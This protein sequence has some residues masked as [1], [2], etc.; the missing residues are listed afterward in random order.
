MTLPSGAPGCGEGSGGADVEGGRGEGVGDTDRETGGQGVIRLTG[1]GPGYT[2][3]GLSTSS[4][5]WGLGGHT[6]ERGEA[7]LCSICCGTNVPT[8]T[9][10]KLPT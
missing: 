1:P 6:Q 2:G 10:F 4:Q 9:D 8:M 7:P 5:W 3:K